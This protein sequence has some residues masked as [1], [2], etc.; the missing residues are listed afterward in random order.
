MGLV[1]VIRSLAVRRSGLRVL[2]VNSGLSLNV[3]ATAGNG[4]EGLA[5][6]PGGSVDSSDRASISPSKVVPSLG[7]QCESRRIAPVGCDNFATT[8]G[9]PEKNSLNIGYLSAVD[10]RMTHVMNAAYN[11]AT[12]REVRAQ[13]A[14]MLV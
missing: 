12:Y 2:R 10:D 11:I 9:S 13:G 3:F 4:K 8:E 7:R 5:G 14:V 6:R 1:K